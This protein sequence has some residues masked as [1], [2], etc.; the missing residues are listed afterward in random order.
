MVIPCTGT[1]PVYP[2]AGAVPPEPRAYQAEAARESYSANKIVVLPTGLGK[3]LIGVLN[4]RRT[5][6]RL[7]DARASGIVVMLAPMKALLVQHREA[8]A[9][10][11]SFVPG[12]L[13]AGPASR[14]LRALEDLGSQR[15]QGAFVRLV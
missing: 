1:R 13:I 3:T 7:L 4:A 6:A 12:M 15:V 11:P 5:I 14:S 10:L 2:L 8:F 9:H